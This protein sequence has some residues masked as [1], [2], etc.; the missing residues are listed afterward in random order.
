[1]P[2]DSDGRELLGSRL[3]AARKAAGLTQRQVAELLSPARG[4]RVTP[5]V[6]SQWERGHRVPSLDR[7]ADLAAVLRT[8]M[9][10]LLEG[11]SAEKNVKM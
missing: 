5:A 2:L 10:S 6:V 9:A 7:L 11:V 1:M 8:T 4:G 3:L